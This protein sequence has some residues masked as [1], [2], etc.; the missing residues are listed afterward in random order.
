MVL[1]FYEKYCCRY[2]SSS[3]NFYF[4]VKNK[5]YRNWMTCCLHNFEICVHLIFTCNHCS[6]QG[7]SQICLW[8]HQFYIVWIYFQFMICTKLPILKTK[9]LL[10][11]KAYQMHWILWN[12]PSN[13]IKRL[14][15]TNF[16]FRFRTFLNF[17][18]SSGFCSFVRKFSLLSF[19]LVSCSLC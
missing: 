8:K 2:T 19:S 17:N 6:G 5:K 11:E 3:I 14:A 9:S 4:C 10:L 13:I 18:C 7:C 1:Q 12:P 15:V 16:S